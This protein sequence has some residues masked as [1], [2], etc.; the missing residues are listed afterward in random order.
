MH[1]G[2]GRTLGSRARR[3]RGRQRGWGE[4]VS[5]VGRASVRPGGVGRR[6][7]RERRGAHHSLAGWYVMGITLLGTITWRCSPSNSARTCAKRASYPNEIRCSKWPTMAQ[8]ISVSG[9]PAPEKEGERC[10]RWGEEKKIRR[11][12]ASSARTRERGGM[13]H[14]PPLGSHE[15]AT[16]CRMRRL[17]VETILIGAREKRSI[18]LA[19]G[20]RHM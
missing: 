14:S 12:P 5:S 15:S 8:V 1:V 4:E 11:L 7:D 20:R 17:R 9:I 16:T 3:E 13:G 19:T 10:G 6:G 18:S 2:R